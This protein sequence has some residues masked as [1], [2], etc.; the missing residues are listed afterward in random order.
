MAAR[1]VPHRG[2][3]RLLM[4]PQGQ[5]E[6]YHGLSEESAPMPRPG[7]WNLNFNEAG[8]GYL[9]EAGGTTVWCKDV[10]RKSCMA[11][12][13]GRIYIHD[14]EAGTTVWLHTE[15]KKITTGIALTS[16]AFYFYVMRLA[17]MHYFWQ[18]RSFQ[19]CTMPWSGCDYEWLRLAAIEI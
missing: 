13:D 17:G 5:N 3:V 18:L 2:H 9:H 6:L 7:N 19:A 14:R 1:V 8:F 12:P 10:L 11:M 15:K 4:S 16:L